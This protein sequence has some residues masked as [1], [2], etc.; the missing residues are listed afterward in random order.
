MPFELP[1]YLQPFLLPLLIAVPLAVLIWIITVR[2]GDHRDL[3]VPPPPVRPHPDGMRTPA[4][5]PRAAAPVRPAAVPVSTDPADRLP[6]LLVDD[7][8]V[9]RAKLLKLFTDAGYE[10]QTAKDGTEALELMSKTRFGVLLTDL[11]MPNMD[12]FELIKSVQGSMETE[13]LPIIAITG[14]EELH[15]RLHQIQGLYGMFHKPWN[16]RE[17]LKRVDTLSTMRRVQA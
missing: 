9:V 15:A 17:L 1:E 11:E 16:D 2:R 3:G 13:D 14:H 5:A 12:G 7:S 6:L 10:A 8:A 4:A